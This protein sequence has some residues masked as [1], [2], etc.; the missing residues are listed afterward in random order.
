V[1]EAKVEVRDAVAE[2]STRRGKKRNL[3]TY[4][5][6]AGASAAS[7]AGKGKEKANGNGRKARKK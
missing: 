2:T 5:A 6:A 4:A 1:E 3:E 7:A